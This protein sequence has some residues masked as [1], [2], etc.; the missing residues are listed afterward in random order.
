M[1]SLV[2]ESADQIF[3]RKLRNL[4]LAHGWTQAEA[5]EK[6]GTGLRNYLKYEKGQSYPPIPKLTDL[7][8]GFETEPHWFF[9]P[10]RPPNEIETLRALLDGVRGHMAGI[11]DLLEEK[12]SYREQLE[13]AELDFA[14]AHSELQR[15]QAKI[16]E[17]ETGEKP[18][19]LGKL[20]YI[21][22]PRP[23]GGPLPEEIRRQQKL[24]EARAEKAKER[25][26]KAIDYA[27]E[28]LGLTRDRFV[29]ATDD[30]IWLLVSAFSQVKPP[31]SVPDADD[32]ESQ[33]LE[34][35]EVH[36]PAEKGRGV[37]EKGFARKEPRRDKKKGEE[38]A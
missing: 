32:R 4:R 1:I 20:P 36:P 18:P 28:D 22:P 5:A 33:A 21:P 24:Y 35:G 34:P 7:A 19:R 38:T 13:R 27:L 17:L 15:A 12:E 16:K 14:R 30:E 10:E 9:E 37:P 26:F 25:S 3:V 11:E 2:K 31:S 23:A 29:N 8:K 6:A